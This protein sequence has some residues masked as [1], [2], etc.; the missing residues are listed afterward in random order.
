VPYNGSEEPPHIVSEEPNNGN[1]EPLRRPQKLR[2]SFISVDYVNYNVEGL[3]DIQRPH[4][5]K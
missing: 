5:I 3:D 2:M 4:F 1:E